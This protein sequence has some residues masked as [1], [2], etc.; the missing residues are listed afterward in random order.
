M[1][2]TRFRVLAAC[3]TILGGLFIPVALATPASAAVATCT[4]TSSITHGSLTFRMPTTANNTFN[5]F[6]E[7]S[8]NSP[9]TPAVGTLQEHLNACYW[10]GSTVRGHASTFTTKLVVDSVFGPLT[11]AALL[12]AQETVSGIE[13]DGIYGPHT[14]ANI[15]FFADDDLLG[16]CAKFGS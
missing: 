1:R 16:R 13:H 8:I 12:S 5:L 15:L 14:R 3:A 6:C 2:A 4:G 10:S 7:L 11:K 9:S